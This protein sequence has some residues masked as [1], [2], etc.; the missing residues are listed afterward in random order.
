MG[1]KS[2]SVPPL[3]RA[4][5]LSP[6]LTALE[7]KAI[8]SNWGIIHKVVRPECCCARPAA[9]QSILW[10]AAGI[11]L[12]PP[13]PGA[14]LRVP[15]AFGRRGGCVQGEELLC[16]FRAASL[17]ARR[18]SRRFA[19]PRE[20]A[21]TCKATASVPGRAELSPH[22]RPQ[23]GGFGHPRLW[24][25]AILVHFGSCTR[26]RSSPGD[27]CAGNLQPSARWAP[28]APVSMEFVLLLQLC[29]SPSVALSALIPFQRVLFFPCKY[30][31]HP[32]GGYN[33][34]YGC[35]MQIEPKLCPGVTGSGSRILTPASG[36]S[37]GWHCLAMG[38]GLSPGGDAHP[39]LLGSELGLW[40]Q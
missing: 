7:M 38:H 6:S 4:A 13:H 37:P 26:S 18:A 1:V 25:V 9:L 32:R 10:D 34:K 33:F 8:R 31:Q 35:I 29:F 5:F 40:G 16:T 39:W 22:R 27:V 19:H 2:V 24:P 3:W 11:S 28:P 20:V 12:L 36:S 21:G 14:G 30:R 15:R 23:C 17:H